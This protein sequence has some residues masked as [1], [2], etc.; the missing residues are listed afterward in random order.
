MAIYNYGLD[1]FT[2]VEHLYNNTKPIRGTG[3]KGMP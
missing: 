1:S 3:G 2:H